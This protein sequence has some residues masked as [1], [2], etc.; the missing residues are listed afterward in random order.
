MDL[1]LD[2]HLALRRALTGWR[3]LHDP[4]REV[5]VLLHRRGLWTEIDALCL[6]QLSAEEVSLIGQAL[7]AGVLAGRTGFVVVEVTRSYAGL[8]VQI[9]ALT[10]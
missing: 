4:E 6:P 1:H 5:L 9:C 7:Q 8:S 10:S 2:L 3:I